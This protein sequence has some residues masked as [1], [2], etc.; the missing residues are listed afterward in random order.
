M[1]PDQTRAP[2][3]LAS[4]LKQRSRSSPSPSPSPARSR[5]RSPSWRQGSFRRDIEKAS[6]SKNRAKITAL[7]K[8]PAPASVRTPRPCTSSQARESRS[9]FSP[10]GPKRRGRKEGQKGERVKGQTSGRG[11]NGQS[12]HSIQEEHVRVLHIVW[13]NAL[14]ARPSAH[15]P[16][17]TCISPHVCA[18]YSR[19]VWCNCQVVPS[20]STRP[21]RSR[22]M[23]MVRDCLRLRPRSVQSTW[24]QD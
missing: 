22:A 11:K 12:S 9:A 18:K 13:W 6:I 4:H 7:R 20:L 5:R 14:D 24:G 16:P 15:F 1:A 21:R 19:E 3:R 10:V 8:S 17:S 23:A 2:F